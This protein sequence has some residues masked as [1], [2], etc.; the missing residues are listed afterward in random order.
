MSAS[1]DR[2]IDHLLSQQHENGCWEGEM[3][4]CTMILSQYIIVRHVTGRPVDEQSRSQMIKYYRANRT[5]EGVWGLHPESGGY[6]FFTT[7]AYVAL[8]LIGLPADDPMLSTARHW[9]KAQ[10]CQ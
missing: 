4:W 6:V 1:L 8:R 9:L 10:M 5:P 7:L 2:G 3:V